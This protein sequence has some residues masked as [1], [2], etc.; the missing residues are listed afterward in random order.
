MLSRFQKNKKRNNKINKQERRKKT[1]KKIFSFLKVFIAIFIITISILSY[2]YYASTSHLIVREYSPNYNNLP[3]NFNGLKIIQFGDL[4][5]DNN[6]KYMIRELKT[7]INK[8]KPDLILF[9]GGL[10]HKDFKVNSENYDKLLD[11]FESID[12]TI[13]KYFVLS[14]NDDENVIDLLEK[15]GFIYVD[16]S[17]EEI[18][19][20]TPT[21][22]YLYGLYDKTDIENNNNDSFKIVLVNDP[23]YVDDIVSSIRPNMVMSGKTLNGQI[24]IPFSKANI[25]NQN[26][27]YYDSYYKIDD[28]DLFITGGI[29]TNN[30]PIRIFNHPSINFY[31]LKSK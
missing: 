6:Y 8:I 22:I 27:K 19:Y 20:D 28:T 5:Y 31:R 11:F 13:G 21:P 26:Y 29:G 17:I 9:T 18:Y 14:S 12:A 16:D 10:Y 7:R 25:L 30:I 3:D 24:K 1:R 15:S 2:M 23:K 4:Y